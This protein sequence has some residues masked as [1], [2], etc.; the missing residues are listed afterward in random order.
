MKK[1]RGE[2]MKKRF[3]L[4]S[5]KIFILVAVPLLARGVFFRTKITYDNKGTRSEARHRHLYI[6]RKLVP[7]TFKL[8][9]HKKTTYEFFTRKYRWGDDGYVKV[10]KV[11]SLS[12]SKK[13]IKKKDKKLGWY[14]NGRKKL[15]GTPS[16]WL[17]VEWDSRAAFVHP[18]RLNALVKAENIQKIARLQ[19]ARE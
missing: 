3:L 13:K 7:D 16:K 11:I 5:I 10:D 15:L 9:A 12:R 8:I 17:Y 4:V 1:R 6:N 2:K 14:F 19:S 18:D